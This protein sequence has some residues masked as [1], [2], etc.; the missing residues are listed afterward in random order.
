MTVFPGDI[1]AEHCPRIHSP[2]LPSIPHHIT[3]TDAPAACAVTNAS[4]PLGRRLIAALK[5]RGASRIVAIDLGF[6]SAS[7]MVSCPFNIFDENKSSSSASTSS[8][9]A[10]GASAKASSSSSSSSQTDI[11]KDVELLSIDLADVSSQ[12]ALSTVLAGVHTVFHLL[13]HTPAIAPSQDM[14]PLIDVAKL[15]GRDGL[16]SK[17]ARD[18]AKAKQTAVHP[19]YSSTSNILSASRRAGVRSVVLSSAAEARVLANEAVEGWKEADLLNSSATTQTTVVGSNSSSRSSSSTS[20]FS[21]PSSVIELLSTT[22]VSDAHQA[23]IAAES[24]VM[25]SNTLSFRTCVLA[26]HNVY[27]PEN[28][29]VS[30]LISMNEAT[31]GRIASG[32]N[33]V[34]SFTHVE[35]LCHALVLAAA[36]LAKPI[37]PMSSSSPAAAAAAAGSSAKRDPVG[38]K[39]LIVTDGDA[40]FLWDVVESVQKSTGGSSN[41]DRYH[42]YNHVLLPVAWTNQLFSLCD[43]KLTPVLV[44]AATQ[45]RYFNIDEVRSV[46][47]YAPLLPFVE[48]MKDAV[49][50][51]KHR[52]GTLH[53][54]THVEK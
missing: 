45:H 47:G 20:S 49:H 53:D 43:S 27:G 54:L 9:S 26:A 28:G 34:V 1:R 35:N 52:W 8:A 10:A 12:D 33:N 22:A 5:L 50:H 14:K 24:L 48:G 39:Y 11:Y 18:V 25:S 41:W 38:G 17:L 32:G 7:V 37:E 21:F 46:L 3:H 4:S 31:W 23:T 2:I 15:L 29:F 51:V 36:A 16:K 30:N 42:V 19:L 40:Q 44:H 6:P 13:P